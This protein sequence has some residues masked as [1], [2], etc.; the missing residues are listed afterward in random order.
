MK[1]F[2]SALLFMVTWKELEAQSR[3]QGFA[4]AC[5]IVDVS[6]RREFDSFMEAS[7]F[8]A[9]EKIRSPRTAY[10]F[11]VYELKERTPQ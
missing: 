6:E 3:G 1:R 8:V 2:V 5:E 11:H 9:K 7:A 4:E 10:D